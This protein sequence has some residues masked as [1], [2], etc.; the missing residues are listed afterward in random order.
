MF[1]VT[2]VVSAVP[3]AWLPRLAACV[4]ALVCAVP[5]LRRVALANLRVAFPEKNEADRR[6]IGRAAA[7]N[8][9]LT[10]LEFLWFARHPHQLKAIIDE[11]EVQTGR[12]IMTVADI[13][14]ATENSS[15]EKTE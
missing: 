4:G 11:L 1:V 15:T 7:A 8:M 3:L 14:T 6:R 9:V 2:H 5:R 13:E 12:Q 10:G